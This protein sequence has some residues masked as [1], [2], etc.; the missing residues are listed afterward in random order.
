MEEKQCVEDSYLYHPLFFNFKMSNLETFWR[1]LYST[2]QWPKRGLNSFCT[3]KFDRT[4]RESELGYYLKTLNYKLKTFDCVYHLIAFLQNIAFIK[5][6]IK[7]NHPRWI[8]RYHFSNIVLLLDIYHFL[9]NRHII[10]ASGDVTFDM[11]IFKKSSSRP[12]KRLV[13]TMKEKL[14]IQCIWLCFQILLLAKNIHW[15]SINDVT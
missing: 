10:T 7:N 14:Y 15:C 3:F 9:T 11:K 4:L 6:G 5:K 2:L 1:Y 13:W 12:K 8:L